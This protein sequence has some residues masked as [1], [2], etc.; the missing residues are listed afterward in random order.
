M[1]LGGRATHAIA[2]QG[3]SDCFLNAS[4]TLGNCVSTSAV[5]TDFGTRLPSTTSML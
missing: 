5:T 1:R 4:N 3:R 2:E